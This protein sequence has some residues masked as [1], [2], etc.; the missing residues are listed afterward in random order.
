[1]NYLEKRFRGYA[2]RQGLF[3]IGCIEAVKQHPERSDRW[4]DMLTADA[5]SHATV[6]AR[7][8]HRAE[9]ARTAGQ[10]CSERAH[11]LTE[12]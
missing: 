9:T 6:A 2:R 4:L 5:Q 3:A 8:A 11:Y 1:M 10:D 7:W 12:W